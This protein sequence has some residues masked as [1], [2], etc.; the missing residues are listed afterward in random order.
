MQTGLGCPNCNR[1]AY[2][3]GADSTRDSKQ[4]VQPPIWAIWI[5]LDLTKEAT[6]DSNGRS[7]EHGPE[8][9]MELSGHTDVSHQHDEQ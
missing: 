1:K 3:S 5:K 2:C 9:P 4:P 7:E 6:N 8:I